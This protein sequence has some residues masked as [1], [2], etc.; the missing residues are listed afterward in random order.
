MFLGRARGDVMS[1][2]LFRAVSTCRY[3]CS[4][5]QNSFSVDVSLSPT[6]LCVDIDGIGCRTVDFQLGFAIFG[7][8]SDKGHGKAEVVVFVLH[9]HVTEEVE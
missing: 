7:D 1:R 2:H 9:L 8:L 4:A 5:K 3:Q 6:H